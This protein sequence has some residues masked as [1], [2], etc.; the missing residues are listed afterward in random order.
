MREICFLQKGDNVQKII[1]KLKIDGEFDI[2]QDDIYNH[3]YFIIKK[4]SEDIQ[5]V[6]NYN[7]Y[8]VSKDIKQGVID[9]EGYEIVARNNNCSIIYKPAGIKYSVKPLDTLTSIAE[10]FGVVEEEILF[11]N[12][13]KTNKLFV[14]QIL[15][16]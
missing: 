6:K 8:I 9:T 14:G 7:P 5:V 3:K 15:V 13:L 12:N 11:K 16:V 4:G 1:Y 10:K 2:V